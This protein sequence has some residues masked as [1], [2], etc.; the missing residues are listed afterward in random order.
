MAAGAINGA[1][2]GSATAVGMSRVRFVIAHL[3]IAAVVGGSFYDIATR[4]EHWPYSNY[5][6]FAEIHRT[7]I[8]RWPRIYGVTRD[9]REVPIVSYPQLWPL[10]QSR[11]PIGLRA[12]VNEPGSSTRVREALRDVLRRYEARRV[13]GEHGGPSLVGVRLYLVSWQVEPFARNLSAPM[14][15]RLLSGVMLDQAAAR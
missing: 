3:L 12:I 1:W 15:R 11:L 5:P 4:M 7:N 9:G 13:A 10:D 14:D 2:M 8:L 6:M